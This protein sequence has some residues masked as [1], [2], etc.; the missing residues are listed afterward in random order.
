VLHRCFACCPAEALVRAGMPCRITAILNDTVGVLSAS[1]Y[2]D[3]ATEMGV[4]LGTGTNASITL[5]VSARATSSATQ[6]LVGLVLIACC[7]ATHCR[8]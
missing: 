8:A 4:I 3:Q 1:C 7:G 6:Q 2:N 5:P